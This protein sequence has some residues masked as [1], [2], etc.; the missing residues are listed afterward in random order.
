[1]KNE[2]LYRIFRIVIVIIIFFIMTLWVNDV[3][4]SY[5][6][7]YEVQNYILNS[8]QV[9]QLSSNIDRTD[10]VGNVSKSSDGFRL[11]LKNTTSKDRDITFIAKDAVSDSDLRIDYKYV[12]YQ[13]ICDGVV[14]KEDVMNNDGILYK[15]ILKKN[16]KNVYEIKFWINEYA[17][18]VDGK[19][20]SVN[21]T[22]I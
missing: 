4:K 1:M 22:L 12:N 6:K 5:D 2:V 7:A 13:I 17:A 10:N 14:V 16:S 21:I 18:Y 3:N 8:L 20:F 15:T 19:K 9:K 11:E